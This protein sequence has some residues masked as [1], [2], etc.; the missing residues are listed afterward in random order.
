MSLLKSKRLPCLLVTVLVLLTGFSIRGLA[1]EK[2]PVD[3][4]KVDT[5]LVVFD[6]QVVDKKPR[7]VI[8]DLTRDDFEVSENGV[9]QPVSY[10]GREELPLSILLLLDVSGSVRPIL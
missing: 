4:I 10:F 1:Q 8:G 7:R 2:E 6:V 3:V 9:R 5:D